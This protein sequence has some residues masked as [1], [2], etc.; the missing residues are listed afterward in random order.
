V[1]GERPLKFS[2][3]KFRVRVENLALDF[4]LNS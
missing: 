1:D 2:L 4:H 3:S